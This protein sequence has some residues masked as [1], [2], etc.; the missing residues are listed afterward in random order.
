MFLRKVKSRFISVLEVILGPVCVFVVGVGFIFPCWYCSCDFSC[1]A[2]LNRHLE[3]FGR[4]DHVEFLR[5]LHLDLEAGYSS[6]WWPDL[7]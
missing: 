1:L 2:D 3:V 7:F 5:L 4:R 6:S